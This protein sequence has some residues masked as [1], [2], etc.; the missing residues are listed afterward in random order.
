MILKLISQSLRDFFAPLPEPE[1]SNQVGMSRKEAIKNELYQLPRYPPFDKGMPLYEVDQIIESQDELIN[2]IRMAFGVSPKEFDSRVMQII[3]NYA[4]YVH[5][6]PATKIEHHHGAGGMFRL[7]LEVGF[8][9][10]QAAAGR[11]FSNR[12]TAEKRRALQPRWLYATFIAGICSEIN[13]PLTNLLVVNEAGDQWPSYLKPLTDWALEIEA[14]K[15]FIQW[16]ENG[17][18]GHQ[19]HAV[20]AFVLNCII[21][22][23]CLQY[24]NADNQ[25]IVTDMTA[26]ITGASRHGDG[27]VIAA[28]VRD[29]LDSVVTTDL[30]SNATHYGH[31][32]LGSHWEVHLMDVMREL[33]KSGVW[34]VNVKQARIWITKEGAFLIWNPAFADI[35]KTIAERKIIGFPQNPDTLAGMMMGSSIVEPNR[36]GGPFWEVIIPNNGKLATALKIVDPALIC[37]MDPYEVSNETLMPNA[38]QQKNI[39]A[40]PVVSA[41]EIKTEVAPAK[42]QEYAEAGVSE[43]STSKPAK[44]EQKPRPVEQQKKDTGTKFDGQE[45][46]E[47][48]SDDSKRLIKAILDDFLDNDTSYP[49]WVSAKGAVI[50]VDEFNSHGIATLKVLE[51]LRKKNWLYVDPEAKSKLTV[52]VE[53]EKG[54]QKYNAYIITKLIADALGFKD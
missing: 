36:D 15:Y 21:P 12:E 44:Q 28:L 17:K 20:S 5:L 37:G 6:L 50:T 22:Q 26:S 3:R 49:V 4:N 27:N 48:L 29:A 1:I 41:P 19:R 40:E 14:D 30:A 45:L 35:I 52:Q 10:M 38:S 46:L 53:K 23:E 34:G 33:V 42:T 16:N 43:S 32:E 18:G 51:E 2:R 39:E 31:Y 47:Q 54:G 7:G 9:A 8:F 25:Q 11:V 24:L 13:R